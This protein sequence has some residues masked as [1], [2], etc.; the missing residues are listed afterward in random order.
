MIEDSNSLSDISDQNI[1]VSPSP[2]L[3]DRKDRKKRHSRRKTT[4]HSFRVLDVD[5]VY[6]P[7]FSNFS[8]DYNIDKIIK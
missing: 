1:D 7:G 6:I 5:K 3:P 8:S 4:T 2:K